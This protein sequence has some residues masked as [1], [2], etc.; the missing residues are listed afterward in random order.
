MPATLSFLAPAYNHERQWNEV[1]IK[2]LAVINAMNA[3]LQTDIPGQVGRFDDSFNI[4]CVGDRL[5]SDGVPTILIEAGH[6]PDDY[7][8]ETTRR[9]FFT[10]LVAGFTTINE[11]V[12]VAQEIAEYLNIPQ[13]K[14]V[15]YDIVYKNIRINYD[16]NELIT[17]FASQYKEVLIDKHIVFNALIS[18]VG[19]IEEFIGHVEYDAEGA[20]FK[21][22]SGNYPQLGN[23]AD[24]YLG[25]T[26]FTNGLPLV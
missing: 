18:A 13:N 20:L 15:F 4:N 22:D 25:E 11:N 7:Q 19:D 12:V 14:T 8:R 2:A 24:F 16:G 17:N 6:Y 9:L 1:R 3:A 26:K 10:S 5:Q 21:D 23:S